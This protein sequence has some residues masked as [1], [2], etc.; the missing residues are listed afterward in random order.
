MRTDS[1]LN[2]LSASAI[3]WS[4]V[5]I[6]KDTQSCMEHLKKKSKNSEIHPLIDRVDVSHEGIKLY[7]KEE[8]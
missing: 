6:F 8:L 1:K 4:F 5:K 2:G 3:K 7:L